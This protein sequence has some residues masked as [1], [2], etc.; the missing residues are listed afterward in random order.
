[1]FKGKKILITGGTGT[2]GKALVWA[3]LKYEPKVIRIFSRSEAEQFFM[4]HELNSDSSL[5][6]NIKDIKDEDYE[7][8]TLRFLIGDIRDKERLSMAM[9][10][11]DIVFHTAAMKHVE[12]S[13]YN[14]FEA[15]KTNV[16]G[17]QNLIDVAFEHNVEKVIYTS[18]DKAANPNNTMGATKLLGERLMTAANYYKGRKRTVFASVRFGNVMGSRG[19]VIPLFKQQIEKG[20]PVTVT[21]PN[22]TRFMMTLS[23][24]IQLVFRCA[25]MASGGEIFILKMPVVR[26]GDLARV[27]IEEHG[28]KIGKKAS[29]I[30]VKIIGAKN[31]ETRFEEL[32]TEEESIRALETDDMFIVPIDKAKYM[33]HLDSYDIPYVEIKQADRYDSRNEPVVDINRLRLML[34]REKLV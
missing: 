2:I 25:E 34:K 17:M 19:S 12:S 22:M 33:R 6:C 4:R 8:G 1:M 21:D 3:L 13:E 11:I 18:S 14:P 16:I 10:D 29:Q 27:V 9:D 32:M 15:V 24:A 26:L 28:S 23:H 7:I 30:Q 5:K 20:C 31:G